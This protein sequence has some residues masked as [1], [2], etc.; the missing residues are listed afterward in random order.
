MVECKQFKLVIVLGII[1]KPHFYVLLDTKSIAKK[2]SGKPLNVYQIKYYW[3][4]SYSFLTVNLNVFLLITNRICGLV[5]S[6]ETTTTRRRMNHICITKFKER[7]NNNIS[8]VGNPQI[9]FKS[10][11]VLVLTILMRLNA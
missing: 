1:V 7:H 5:F 10:L 3:N 11:D 8:V 6:L 2:L 9:L 4:K